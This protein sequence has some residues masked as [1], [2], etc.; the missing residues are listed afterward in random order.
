M[1]VTIKAHYDG[2][3]IVP[4]EPVDLPI[5]QPLSVQLQPTPSEVAAPAPDRA[6]EAVD[7][8][9]AR[10]IHGVRIP[11]EALHREHLYEDRT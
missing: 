3:V 6:R 9:V 7:R 11:D 10:A 1:I 5:N 4:D 2:K 8:L